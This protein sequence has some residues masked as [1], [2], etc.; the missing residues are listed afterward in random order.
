MRGMARAGN[1]YFCLSVFVFSVLSI[2]SCSSRISSLEL[3][4]DDGDF[5]VNFVNKTDKTTEIIG[6][7][8]IGSPP[9]YG[10]IQWSVESSGVMAVQCM[11]I[12]SYIS[13][14]SVEPGGALQMSVNKSFLERAFCVPKGR[15]NVRAYYV[16]DDVIYSNVVRSTTVDR[17]T[18]PR[19]Q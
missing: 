6:S 8:S 10:T 19:F 13:K 2:S 3:H 14:V 16:G 1:F 12:D 5:N 7:A 18:L 9:G 17:P 15:Y 11:H 4:E